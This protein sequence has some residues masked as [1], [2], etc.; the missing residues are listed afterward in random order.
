MAGPSKS[1]NHTMLEM[2]P[3]TPANLIF[4]TEALLIEPP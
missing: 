1:S 4:I 3:P 2:M